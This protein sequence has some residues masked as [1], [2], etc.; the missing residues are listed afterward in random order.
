VRVCAR[1]HLKAKGAYRTATLEL[2]ATTLLDIVFAAQGHAFVQARV[3]AL[4]RVPLLGFPCPRFVGRCARGAAHSGRVSVSRAAP[5]DASAASA[6]I[7]PQRAAPCPLSR[8]VARLRAAPDATPARSSSL[9]LRPSRSLSAAQVR[10]SATLARLLRAK[11]TLLRLELP[12]RPFMALLR[13]T[14]LNRC[15]LS[16]TH[17]TRLGLHGNTHTRSLI[18]SYPSASIFSPPLF[19]F[20]CAHPMQ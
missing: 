10:W 15:A 20:C 6:R 2:L 7:A 18:I 9:V 8:A 1:S 12:W 4:R 19:L 5:R 14:H 17:H 3:R 16:V 11:K 13:D